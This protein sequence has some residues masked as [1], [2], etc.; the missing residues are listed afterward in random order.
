M[1][2]V[3]IVRSAS[4]RAKQIGLGHYALPC[5]QVPSHA[6]CLL[7][8]ARTTTQLLCFILLPCIPGLAS[9]SLQL[10]EQVQDC[11]PVMMNGMK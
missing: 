2:E 4:D 10:Q 8:G 11:V 3:F 9:L 5:K 7:Q 1:F 6:P